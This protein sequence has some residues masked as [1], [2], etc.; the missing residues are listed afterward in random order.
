M[1]SYHTERATW[2]WGDGTAAAGDP[3]LRSRGS[4]HTSAALTARSLT[5]RRCTAQHSCLLSASSHLD[6]LLPRSLP[7]FVSAQHDSDIP[8]AG[9][10]CGSPLSQLEVGS[11]SENE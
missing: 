2:G 10:L 6:L 5:P 3:L 4:R 11:K 1:E 8:L 9:H 7:S